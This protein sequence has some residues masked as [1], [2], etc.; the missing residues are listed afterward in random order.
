[1]RS[2]DDRDG[3]LT[4]HDSL[5]YDNIDDSN[6]FCDMFLTSILVK[7]EIFMTRTSHNGHLTSLWRLQKLRTCW[8]NQGTG[9]H[10][11]ELS[12]FSNERFDMH[13]ESK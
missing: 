4:I 12:T 9:Q 2:E 11:P 1:M 5:G 13:M 3:D 10:V 8:I 6:D 7:C